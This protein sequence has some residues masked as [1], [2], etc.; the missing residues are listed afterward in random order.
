MALEIESTKQIFRDRWKREWQE[1]YCRGKG[2]FLPRTHTP[3][4][5]RAPE[6]PWHLYKDPEFVGIRWETGFA[7]ITADAFSKMSQAKINKLT[8]GTPHEKRK[9]VR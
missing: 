1:K 6:P 8:G 4:V 7:I 9:N 2:L 3:D 5:S